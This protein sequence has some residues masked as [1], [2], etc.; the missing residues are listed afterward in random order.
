MQRIL[1]ILLVLVGLC[2]AHHA[3]AKTPPNILLILTDDQGWGDVGSH[4]ND[5]LDT[6]VLDRLASQGARFERFYV[7][8]VCAPTRASLL[9]GRDHLRTGVSWVTRNHETMRAEEVTLAE[10]LQKAGYHTGCFGKWHN[11]AYYP[12]DPHGQGFDTFVGFRGGHWNNYFDTTL[13]RNRDQVKTNGYISDVLTDAAMEFIRTHKNQPFFCYVPYNAPHSPFQVPDP[14][15]DK[16]RQRGLDAKNACVYAMV[17]NLDSNIGRL[18]NLLDTLQLDQNTIVVFLTD[19]GPNTK[20]FNGD[21][22]GRKGSVHEGGVRVPCFVRFPGVIPAGTVVKPIAAH[23]DLMPTL[24]DLCGVQPP[25][26]VKFDG[27]SLMPLVQGKSADAWPDRM[28]FSHQSRGGKVLPAPGAVRTQ[29][30]RLVHDRGAWQLFDMQVD[31]G[32]KT[33]VAADH[34]EVMNQLRRAYQDWF[35]AV[36][37][38]GL[39][40]IP[41]P[42]GYTK[43]PVVDIT[44]PEA[45]LTGNVRYHGKAGWANDW[46]DHWTSPEDTI[47]WTVEVATPGKYAFA[48]AYCCPAEELGSTVQLSIAGKQLTAKVEKAHNPGPLPT[49]DRVPRGEVGEKPWGELSLGTLA[50]PA[51]LTTLT[52]QAPQVAGKDVMELK[53]VRVSLRP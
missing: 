9:T 12:H 23:I 18:L 39:A 14:L 51:G 45:Q 53:A 26:Q 29:R 21:M 8:P 2:F 1:G 33:D 43:A 49:P 40:S 30:W 6:P 42:I 50:L 52:L 10:V 7:S 22:R 32:Q 31:P 15:F 13:D 4:S 44:A 20:R 34:P 5:K 41:I 48:L 28:L 17:E 36:T 37:E 24:L 11:G 16:Y 25:A 38:A 19:N 46:I 3:E 47:T 35:A 27:K